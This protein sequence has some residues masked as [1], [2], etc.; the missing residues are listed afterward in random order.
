MEYI[1]PVTLALITSVLGP[2]MVE[3][4]KNKLTPPSK[5]LD[6]LKEAVE[7]N[8]VIDEQ[9]EAIQHEID[10]DRIWLAQFHN[11]GHFYPTGKS[12]QK[13]SLF[14]EKITPN[15]PS[16]IET[17]QNIPV[18]LYSKALGVLYEDRE[19]IIKNTSEDET[20]GIPLVDG[21]NGSKS[22]YMITL[23]DIDDR[24]IGVLSISYIHHPHALTRDEWIFIRNKAGQI[25]LLLSNYLK[26]SKK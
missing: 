6:P 21:E 26:N 14:Y 1:L 13:F 10:C 9:L 11:G 3:W 23:H 15:T 22:V 5:P 4:V 20:Y 19:L 25:G 24:F 8:Q 17:F 16:I 2:V 18:S 7:F 12:I